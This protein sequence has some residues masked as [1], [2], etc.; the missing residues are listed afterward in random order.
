MLSFLQISIIPT[1]ILVHASVAANNYCEAPINTSE[2][3][4]HWISGEVRE[5]AIL[6]KLITSDSHLGSETLKSTD[7]A[8]PLLVQHMARKIKRELSNNSHESKIRAM[9]ELQH[10]TI[11][12]LNLVKTQLPSGAGSISSR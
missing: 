12:L 3:D 11:D 10:K 5:I 6:F 9:H 2:I 1:L 4:I 8:P 7:Y